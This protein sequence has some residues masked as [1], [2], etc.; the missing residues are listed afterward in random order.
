MMFVYPQWCPQSPLPKAS[1]QSLIISLSKTKLINIK[2]LP[3]TGTDV[4]TNP[5]IKT[6]EVCSTDSDCS[7]TGFCNE[8]L[9]CDTCLL[10]SDCATGSCSSGVCAQVIAAETTT[11]VAV[12]TVA[13][14]KIESNGAPV[15]AADNSAAVIGGSVGGVLGVGMIAAGVYM[16]YTK[17]TTTVLEAPMLV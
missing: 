11:T 15:V 2:H 6:G 12:P 8:L 14:V 1:R 9:F 3:P 7:V 10:D 13:E 5:A 16:Y 17:K 4:P